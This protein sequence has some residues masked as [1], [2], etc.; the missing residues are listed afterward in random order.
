MLS[1]DVT[2]EETAQHT[3]GNNDRETIITKE[4]KSNW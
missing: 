3:K 2:T 4:L 1:Q